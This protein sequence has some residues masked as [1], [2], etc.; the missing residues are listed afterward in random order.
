MS[1]VCFWCHKNF[2]GHSFSGMPQ[3]LTFVG[4]FYS[5]SSKYFLISL[6]VFTVTHKL[7]KS[8]KYGF[9]IFQ[10]CIDICYDF[11]FNSI[12]DRRCFVTWNTFKFIDI[13][14]SLCY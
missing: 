1:P 3:I 6:F 14:Y 4:F 9:Q 7:F 13:S 11:K 10:D 2:P 12:E 8:V 5:F